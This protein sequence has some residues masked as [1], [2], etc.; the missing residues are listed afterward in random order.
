MSFSLYLICLHPQELSLLFNYSFHYSNQL[1]NFIRIWKCFTKSF[2][3]NSFK[4][5][6]IFIDEYKF[7]L[8]ILSFLFFPL[9]FLEYTT[10]LYM[11]S[12]KR[13]TLLRQKAGKERLDRKS[14]W[15]TAWQDGS[16]SKWASALVTCCCKT[17]IP[18]C[19]MHRG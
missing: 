12:R 13:W 3:N 16:R 2:I 5:N 8:L 19:R 10:K 11:N 4:V 18:K 9:L 17:M 1:P 7:S 6:I 14:L 15:L